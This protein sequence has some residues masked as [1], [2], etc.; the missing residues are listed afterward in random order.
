[1]KFLHAADLHLDR[2]FEGLTTIPEYFQE[3]LATANKKMLKNIVDTAITEAVDFIL[4]VGDT[5][6]QNRP[7][8]KT[9]RYFFQEMA[10]LDE[11]KI[12]VF[13][14]FWKS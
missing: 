7:T 14:K 9:Q 1:M 12:P 3:N 2:S 11:A 5:F 6:H 13:M 8:L 4:F 10:R